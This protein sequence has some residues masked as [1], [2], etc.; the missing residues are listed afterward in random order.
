M[1]RTR[2]GSSAEGFCNERA[3]AVSSKDL[4]ISVAKLT[5]S[6]VF[7]FCIEELLIVSADL[8]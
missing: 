3:D 6:G 7:L 8:S 2:V 5:I 4:L 1:C